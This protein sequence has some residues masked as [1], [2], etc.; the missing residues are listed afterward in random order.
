[1]PLI[2]GGGFFDGF[3]FAEYAEKFRW[4]PNPADEL[5]HRHPPQNPLLP[6]LEKLATE[7]PRRWDSR[8]KQ[9]VTND[10]WLLWELD[11]A[12]QSDAPENPPTISEK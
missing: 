8:T 6:F 7:I 4:E 12:P 10:D 2:G 3:G 5:E 11:G 1:M 9:Y